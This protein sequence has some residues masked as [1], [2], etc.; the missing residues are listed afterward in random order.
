MQMQMLLLAAL[1]GGSARGEQCALNLTN[2]NISCGWLNSSVELWLPWLRE[3]N[4]TANAAALAARCPEHSALFGGAE[5]RCAAGYYNAS[6]GRIRCFREHEDWAADQPS[7]SSDVSGPCQP[8]AGTGCTNQIVCADGLLT[9]SENFAA[10]QT[11]VGQGA[12]FG[13]VAGLPR[14]VFP[15]ER[16]VTDPGTPTCTGDL[17]AGQCAAGEHNTNGLLLGC[18]SR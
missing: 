17:S 10:S 5:C 11:A 6:R 15:C 2:H 3:A 1:V 13:D 4:A 14:G 8:C 16:N 9:L 12:A 18:L 7:T